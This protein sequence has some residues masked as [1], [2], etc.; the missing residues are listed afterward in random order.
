MTMESGARLFHETRELVSTHRDRMRKAH[1][2]LT[3]DPRVF[4]FGINVKQYGK[5]SMEQWEHEFSI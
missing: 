4:S 2:L 3:N 1:T 5:D